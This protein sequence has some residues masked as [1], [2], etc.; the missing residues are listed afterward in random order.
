LES[1]QRL[2]ILDENCLY[3][4]IMQDERTFFNF[5]GRSLEIG[6]DVFDNPFGQ[7]EAEKEFCHRYLLRGGAGSSHRPNGEE[8]QV[9][10]IVIIL[11]W[12]IAV[13]YDVWFGGNL[14]YQKA[15]LAA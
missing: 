4:D 7:I 8:P 13:G 9:F 11:L 12:S 3:Q 15:E 10:P 1:P 14:F 2:L 6:C 5:H